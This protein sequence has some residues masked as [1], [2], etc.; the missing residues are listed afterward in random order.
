M[1]VS[2]MEAEA[3]DA[4]LTVPAPVTVAVIMRKETGF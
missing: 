3:P 1:W 2:L 4:A